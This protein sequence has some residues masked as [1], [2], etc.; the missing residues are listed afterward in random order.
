MIIAILIF[1]K[2]IEFT[3]EIKW[4]SG[5]GGGEDASADDG[6]GYYDSMVR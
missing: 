5:Y 1:F 2:L 6:G 4:G 3:N